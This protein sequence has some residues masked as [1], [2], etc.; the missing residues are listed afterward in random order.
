MIQTA[1]DNEEEEIPLDQ[2]ELEVAPG[3]QVEDDIEK[4]HDD[5]EEDVKLQKPDN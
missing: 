3:G 1:W 2:G 5:V 4:Q